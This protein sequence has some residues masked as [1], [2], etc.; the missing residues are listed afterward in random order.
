MLRL[1]KLTDKQMVSQGWVPMAYEV[2]DVAKKYLMH[3]AGVGPLAR[4]W[5][6]KLSK[7][8]PTQLELEF[9]CDLIGDL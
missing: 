8:Q 1:I 7:P 6:E 5:L 3:G 4:V 9:D 2:H